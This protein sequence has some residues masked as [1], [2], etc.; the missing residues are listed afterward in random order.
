MGLTVVFTRLRFEVIVMLRYHVRALSRKDLIKNFQLRL[1]YEVDLAFSQERV[2]ADESDLR[3]QKPQQTYKQVAGVLS[4]CQTLKS[5][6]YSVAEIF[7]S[8]PQ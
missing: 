1:F 2:S 4:I 8:Q 5:S 3:R 6:F 7:S